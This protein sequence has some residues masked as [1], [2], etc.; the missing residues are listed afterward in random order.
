MSDD[1]VVYVGTKPTMNYVLAV[2]T[3]FQ[4]GAKNV[5]VKARGKQISKAVDVV[6]ILKNKFL[7]EVKVGEI[8]IST[9][10]LKAEKG[11]INVSVISIPLEK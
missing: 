4:N 7:K 9:E 5:L 8:S 11:D 1:S 6:E 10:T 2:M 3:Q